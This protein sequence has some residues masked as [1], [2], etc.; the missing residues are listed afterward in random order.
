MPEPAPSGPLVLVVDDEESARVSLAAIL[1][2]AGH[3]VL[4]AAGGRAALQRFADYPVGAVVTDIVMTNGD[5]VSLIASLKSIQPRL[6]IVAISGK[7]EAGLAAAKAVGADEI[8]TKPV[9]ADV[10]VT[11]VG[12]AVGKRGGSPSGQ[13]C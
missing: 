7:A 8:L 3:R 5:G 12:R 6:P 4:T 11:A 2:R 1:E 13:G 10:L 9:D